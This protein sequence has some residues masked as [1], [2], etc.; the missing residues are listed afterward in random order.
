M[1]YFLGMSSFPDKIEVIIAFD[2]AN[3]QVLGDSI[4]II[5]AEAAKIISSFFYFFYV[6]L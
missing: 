2:P 6:V 5:L 4:G 1:V 3:G